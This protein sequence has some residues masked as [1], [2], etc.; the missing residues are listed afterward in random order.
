MLNGFKTIYRK[1][2][3]KIW[4][5][6]LIVLI[7]VSRKTIF[8]V[9]REIGD[10]NTSIDSGTSLALVAITLSLVAILKNK[11]DFSKI[12]KTNSSFIA[13][14]M[15]CLLSF[16]WAGHFGTITF[17]AAE[18]LCCFC[19]VGLIIN[20]ISS[21]KLGLYYIIL[22]A[23]I[24]TYISVFSSFLK[25]G[26][27]FIHTNTYSLSAMTGLLLCIGAV[28]YDIFKFNDMKF[29]ILLDAM[30]LI[31]GTS[32][33]SW[34]AFIIGII[35]LYSINKNGLRL[36]R[37]TIVCIITYIA[38]EFAFD[39]I[40]DIIFKGKTKEMIESGTGRDVIWEAAFA[41]W[42]DS[43]LL[44]SGFLIGERSLGNY[45]LNLKVISSHNTFLSVLV[46]TG[47]VGMFLFAN[48]LFRWIGRLFVALKHNTY[49][50]VVFSVAIAVIVNCMAFP[51]IGSD[52]NF[53]AP[54]VYALVAF[55]F[56]HIR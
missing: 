52:W 56:I 47:I 50:T 24:I 23:T 8:N 40:S 53:V 12:R 11:R 34:I 41:S 9:T 30:A 20:K 28:R 7:F 39:Q 49:A 25:F 51:A 18:V 44:G 3:K 6:T 55:V 5:L 21:A 36:L 27:I 1:Y 35:I 22:L 43:P 38:Y 15:L 19:V 26:V 17:K 45:G 42:K 54:V 37:T 14:Y 16:L 48:F 33:A 2:S 46:G 13:Y 29:Y 4:C 10:I 32:S 31:G